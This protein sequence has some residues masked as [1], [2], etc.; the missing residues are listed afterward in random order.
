MPVQ[1]CRY[2]LTIIGLGITTA[3]VS[4][5]A[6]IFYLYL[7]HEAR[8]R[9]TFIQVVF[10]TFAPTCRS[11]YLNPAVMR[12]LYAVI[13]IL[14]TIATAFHFHGYWDLLTIIKHELTGG[15]DKELPEDGSLEDIL[16]EIVFFLL[17]F[18]GQAC[19]GVGSTNH[20][21]IT[22]ETEMGEE[23]IMLPF[24]YITYILGRPERGEEG[25]EWFVDVI[26]PHCC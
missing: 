11:N 19:L 9:C 6:S 22:K 5:L 16:P 7:H 15:L 13:L 3:G 21:G 20:F 25:E 1:C 17:G 26:Y 24:I 14:S 10:S 8:H 4:Y 18:L 12:I 23:G 2:A